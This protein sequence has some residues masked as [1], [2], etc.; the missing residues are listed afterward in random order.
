MKELKK[1]KFIHT[2]S[3][4]HWVG[5]GFHVHSM[6]QPTPELN[7]AISP[8]LLMDYAPE[9]NFP[10]ASKRRGVGEHPHRGF[11]TV[12]FVYSGEVEHKDSSGAGGKIGPGDVQWMTAAS[13]IVHEEMHSQE[14]T[15]KGGPFEMVQLWVN[16]PKDLKMSAP[17]YQ[18]I[19]DDQFPR[20]DLG[21]GDLI[22]LMAGVLGG[23]QGPCS[24]NSPMTIFDMTLK[25]ESQHSIELA[26]DTNTLILIL[27]GTVQINGKASIAK[28]LLIFEREGKWLE[29][30]ASE[31]SKILVL[32][33]K[34]L[35][36]PVF[37]HGPF[38][39]T[40]REEVLKAFDDYQQGKM[41]RLE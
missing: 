7:H 26:E 28:D 11:E 39:M 9:H 20:L 41:G 40:T 19:T 13:G 36:D 27:R 10:P 21:D 5:D 2:P 17:K 14:Y 1:I 4:K 12:T 33:G 16:L 3:V 29:I 15:E 30:S 38:V 6:F 32:N 35:E 23:Q 24:T 34:P 22:R 8:F 25:K 31:D 18:G 37:A